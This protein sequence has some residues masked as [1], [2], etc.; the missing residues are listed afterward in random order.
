M[1]V[2]WSLRAVS[3]ILGL[4]TITSGLF[5]KPWVLWTLTSFDIAVLYPFDIDNAVNLSDVILHASYLG[6]LAVSH[7]AIFSHLGAQ[8][9]QCCTLKF[10]VIAVE[11]FWI[12][13]QPNFS[14]FAIFS[15]NCLCEW[16]MHDVL[17]ARC[18]LPWLNSF[19]TICFRCRSPKGGALC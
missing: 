17:F 19:K 15:P 8:A 7:L 3:N 14:P 16:R 4:F 10:V 9:L 6:S 11:N 12:S 13:S 2:N 5:I 1:Y 18:A